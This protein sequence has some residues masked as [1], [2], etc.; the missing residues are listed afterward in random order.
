MRLDHRRKIGIS[1]AV[2][3]GV[4][5]IPVLFVGRLWAWHGLPWE[6]FAVAL[7]IFSVVLSIASVTVPP[8]WQGRSKFVTPLNDETHVASKL[9]RPESDLLD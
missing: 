9:E 4:C 2:A 5:L 1:F 7:G 3:G 8:F 6:W